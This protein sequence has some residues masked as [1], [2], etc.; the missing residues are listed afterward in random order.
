MLGT[1]NMLSLDFLTPSKV[2][3]GIIDSLK[4]MLRGM[5][6]IFLV[7][8]ILI[9]LVVLLNKYMKKRDGDKED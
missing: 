7:T 2:D 3:F 8:G 5:L 6:S 9:L 4:V 1:T